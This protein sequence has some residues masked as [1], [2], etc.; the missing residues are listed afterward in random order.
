M[1]KENVNGALQLLTNNTNYGIVLL[2]NETLHLLHNKHPEVQ[3]THENVI[4]Q[5][6]VKQVHAVL[7]KAIDKMLISKAVLNT[8]GGCG[9]TGFGTENWHSILVSKSFGWSSLEFWKLFVNF[10]RT[11]C[12]R[13]LN[14]SINSARDTLE[15]TLLIHYKSF[16]FSE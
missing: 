12:T 11:L 8:K 5:E 2:T 4:L 1:H 3:N 16:N 13:T 14:I 9:P 15:D 7:Y 10:I 6:P